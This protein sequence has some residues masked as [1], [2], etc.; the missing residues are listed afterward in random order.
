MTPESMTPEE[1]VLAAVGSAEFISA[2]LSGLDALGE[3]PVVQ[4]CAGP[5]ALGPVQR[6]T[7]RPVDLAIGA[8][9]QFVAFDGR[10]THTSNLSVSEGLDRCAGILAARSSTGR[11]PG[12]YVRTVAGD[13]QLTHSRKGV[14]R[15][16]RHGAGRAAQPAT[17]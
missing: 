2:S 13:L 5:R 9:L 16:I 1:I 15:L 17:V 6:I 10:R 14:S 4:A 7:I 11:A 3:H 12:I 8:H